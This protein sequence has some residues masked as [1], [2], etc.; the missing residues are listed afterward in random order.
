MWN[1]RKLLPVHWKKQQPRPYNLVIDSDFASPAARQWLPSASP[2]APV[3]CR[4]LLLVL[5]NIPTARATP[6]GSASTR[7][8]R[9]T[10]RRI[11]NSEVRD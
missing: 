5:T 1:V 9:R 3:P 11:R 8:H 7:S 10:S 4:N 2:S 6:R